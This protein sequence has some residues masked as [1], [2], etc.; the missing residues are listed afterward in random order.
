MSFSSAHCLLR[1]LAAKQNRGADISHSKYNVEEKTEKNSHTTKILSQPFNRL[2]KSPSLSTIVARTWQLPKPVFVFAGYCFEFPTVPNPLLVFCGLAHAKMFR[3]FQPPLSLLRCRAY[4][5]PRILW[6]T[7]SPN[8]RTPLAYTEWSLK[9]AV[10]GGGVQEFLLTLVPKAARKSAKGSAVG[11]KKGKTGM[12]FFFLFPFL[13]LSFP[14]CSSFI[15]Y[16][17]KR[18]D[19]LR[20]VLCEFANR[21]PCSWTK[22]DCQRIM[23][24]CSGSTLWYTGPVVY[25]RISPGIFER[26]A[27]CQD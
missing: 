19:A 14:F 12:I 6:H 23:H 3:D 13:S 9:E 22:P 24:E 1:P 26:I 25:F 7:D 11:W 10:S 27:P 5:C 8:S 15:F 21:Q 16:I 4:Y 20:N 17:G 18:E 2:T